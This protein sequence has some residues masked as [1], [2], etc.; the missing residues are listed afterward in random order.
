MVFDEA[1][2]GDSAYDRI[3]VIVPNNAVMGAYLGLRIRISTQD[4]MTP[5]E[6]I[7]IFPLKKYLE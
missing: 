3:E 7:I 1:D 4:D 5:Y 2:T 6:L